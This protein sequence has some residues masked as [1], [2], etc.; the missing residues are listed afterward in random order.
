MAHERTV[1]ALYANR[2]DAQKAMTRLA[3]SGIPQEHIGYLEPVDE[4]ELKNP[5]RGAAEGIAAGTTS[6]AVVGAILASVMVAMVPGIGPALVAGSLLPAVLGAVAGGAAG[7]TVGGLLGTDLAGDDELFFM[8][9][10]HAGR[11]LVSAEVERGEDETA[12]LLAES[13][14]LEVD[15]LGTAKLH[16]RLRRLP[17]NDRKRRS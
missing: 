8:Q 11:I 5:A 9:E 15:R 7:G 10:V 13:G 2:E 17:E 1:V 12:K 6:G 3:E 14:A 4:R 16:A